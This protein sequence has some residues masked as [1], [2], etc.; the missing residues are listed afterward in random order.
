MTVIHDRV[1]RDFWERKTG[2]K[3]PGAIYAIGRKLV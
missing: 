2:K 3:I 1:A